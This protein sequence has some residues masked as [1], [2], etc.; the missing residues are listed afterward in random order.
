MVAIGAWQDY[1]ITTG[2]V[3]HSVLRLRGGGEGPGSL[4]SGAVLCFTA[5]PQQAEAFESA[6]FVD[7]SEMPDLKPL[8]AYHRSRA[9]G[10]IMCERFHQTVQGPFRR[11]CLRVGTVNQLRQPVDPEAGDDDQHHLR[12]HLLADP[13]ARIGMTHGAILRTGS[14]ESLGLSLG[15]G[16][17]AEAEVNTI[18]GLKQLLLTAAPAYASLMQRGEHV[19]FS[20]DHSFY[21]VYDGEVSLDMLMQKCRLLDEFASDFTQLYQVLPVFRP[22]MQSGALGLVIQCLN[23][24]AASHSQ[25]PRRYCAQVVA[26]LVAMR[27]YPS[28]IHHVRRCVTN[29]LLLIWGTR[30]NTAKE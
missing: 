4:M 16:L 22:D 8:L 30:R 23:G 5:T 14:W 2:S 1:N 26:F 28:V 27:H 25:M 3:L 17:G 12:G 19:G 9:D 24:S 13:P 7:R 6:E 15:L 21:T 11:L 18:P 20:Q 10:S 29:G